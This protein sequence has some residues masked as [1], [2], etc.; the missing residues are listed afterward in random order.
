MTSEWIS[1]KLGYLS[2]LRNDGRKREGVRVFCYHGVIERKSDRLERNLQLLSDFRAHVRFL[3]RFRVLSL[4]ELVAELSAKTKQNKPAA[5]I[6]FD[7][8][9][10]NNL[11]AAEILAA[12][13]LPWTLF[14]TTGA[15]GREN[16]IWTVELSLLLLQG[17]AERL[18]VLDKSWPL[19]SRDEREAAFQSIRYPLKAM[20]ADLRRRTMDSIRQQFPQGENRRLLEKFP[21]LQ[22]LSWEEVRQLAGAEVEIGS[23]GVNHE[24]HNQAQPETI[25]R[26]E[27]VQSRLELERQLDRSCTFFAFPNGDCTADSSDDVQAAGYRLAFTTQAGTVLPGANPYMLP[28]LEPYGP[29]RTFARNFFWE[30]PAVIAL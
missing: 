29:L 28:R 16:S 15:V 20:P 5:A 7:D 19:T 25:R 21:S 12:Y 23:H 22:M 1:T 18:E 9:F 17:E 14:I 13:H 30:P 10:A 27:L 26:F 11:L 4:T 3:R 6:T 8:G 24:I 2:G